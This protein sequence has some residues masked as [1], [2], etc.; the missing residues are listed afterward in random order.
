MVSSNNKRPV[1]TAFRDAVMK[2]SHTMQL[3]ENGMPEFTNLGVGSN[4]LAISQ[5]V[6]GGDP[7]SLA[8]EILFAKDVSVQDLVDLVIL[9]L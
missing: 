9:S 8:D 5:M 7:T 2:D 6:R 3:G 4:I 1:T